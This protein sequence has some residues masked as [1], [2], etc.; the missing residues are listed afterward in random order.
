MVKDDWRCL[1]LHVPLRERP[2]GQLRAESG[3]GG[4]ASEPNMG[5]QP[6]A[7]SVRC[8]PAF[9]SRSPR[10]FGVFTYRVPP[11]VVT[12]KGTQERYSIA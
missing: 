4:H 2:A 3:P 5:L 7:R 8:T 9:G 11:M 10:A 6:T 1:R 12:L